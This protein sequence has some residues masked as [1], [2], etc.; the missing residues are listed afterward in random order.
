MNRRLDARREIFFGPAYQGWTSGTITSDVYNIV[1]GYRLGVKFCSW[2]EVCGAGAT[3]RGRV[4]TGTPWA[5]CRSSPPRLPR[6]GARPTFGRPVNPAAPPPR[7][8]SE[9]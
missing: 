7:V 6:S 9:P 8:P 5:G 3:G 1:V 2:G 4:L